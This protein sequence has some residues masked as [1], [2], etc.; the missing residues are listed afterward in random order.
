MKRICV[1]VLLVALF[2]CS[3]FAVTTEN[4]GRA[5]PPRGAA[6]DET[7][8][9]KLS[10][11]EG[12]FQNRLAELTLIVEGLEKR[13]GD[14]RKETTPPAPQD[15]ERLDQDLLLLEEESNSLMTP[16]L[17]P[18]AK[19][20]RTEMQDRL[21]EL[22][23]NLELMKRRW[24]GGWAV[25]GADFFRNSPPNQNPEQQSVPK[26]YRLR[27][28]DKL[29]VLVMSALGA[30][31]EYHLTV[32]S[33]GG[34]I[35]PGAG[36]VV[37][38]GKTTQ[39][40]EGYLTS[41]IASKFKQ[42][43]IDVSVENL[44]TI[45]VQVTG[46]VTRPG[47]YFL[48]GMP[49]VLNALYRAGGPTK[50]GTFRRMALIRDGEP[51]RL[52]DLYPFLLEGS[53]KQDL[54][55]EDGDVVFVPPVGPT[56]TVGGEVVR[57]GR[58]E[59]EYPTTLGKIL[60]MAG[61]AKSGGYLQTVQVERIENNQY[62][63]LLSE[64]MNG[65][66]GKSSF[67]LKPGDEVTVASVRQDR[68][69]Q[70]SITGPV[71][72]SGMYGFKEGMRVADL[73][74]LA[75]GLA[76]D[77]EV[78]GG[79]A[80]ILRIDPANG[81]EIVSYNLDKA[82]SGDAANNV[83]L[84]K[85]DRVFIYEPY[86]VVFKARLVTLSGAVARPG[87]YQRQGGMSVSDAIAA[88]GGVLPSAYMKRADL[89]RHTDGQQTELVRIDLQGALNGDPSANVKLADR[90]ELTIYAEDEVVWQDRKVRVEGAVQRAGTYTR[91]ENM[92]VSDLLFAAG[93]ELPE[94]ARVAEVARC[95]K[96]GI[97][98]VMKVDLTAL[99]ASPD[100]DLLLQEGDVVT[101]PSV[102]PYLRTPEVV[103]VTGEVAHPGPYAMM[104]PDER[105]SDLIARAGGVTKSADT[106]GCL[107]LR[108]KDNF[109]NAQ[110]QQDVDML[111]QRSQMLADKQFLTQLAKLGVRLPDQFMQTT[112]KSS[113]E[114]SK[115]A[116]VVPEEKLVGTGS[117]S[118]ESK[119]LRE[120]PEQA[121]GRNANG[122]G[123]NQ[124][125]SK[126]K[127]PNGTY[128][129]GVPLQKA[130]SEAELNTEEAMAA[131]TGSKI[132]ASAM[133]PALAGAAESASTGFKAKQELAEVVQSARISVNLTK[134][135]SE[136][137][138]P[139][140]MVLHNGDRVF[141]PKVTDVVTVIGA[142]LHPHSFSAGPGK[143]VD[144]YIQR[145]GGYSQEASKGQV[146]VVRANGDAVPKAMVRSVEPGD[147]IVV[148]TTG[149]I[150][151]ANKWE[152]VGGVTKVITD[153]L[154]S[155]FVLTRF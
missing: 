59:P 66:D 130:K 36:R 137:N 6:P 153:V 125:K 123:A 69:N 76:P 146:V 100:G 92:R 5:E 88:A 32:E 119:R 135:L 48:S 74:K 40:L 109:Q 141:V 144:F 41:K 148:P 68:T 53:K 51:K 116:E 124:D 89:M 99:A 97:S 101:V 150:D 47:T 39:Q 18:L 77:K 1:H 7:Q 140:N 29:R 43:R 8:A 138:S 129:N 136:P 50:S 86:Q 55:L 120:N 151:I 15:I 12:D 122:T 143:S 103:Y 19:L 70:V 28:G 73:V 126:E 71:G 105:I 45:Q 87:V 142:V 117:E 60:A 121:N 112:N 10:R 57:P 84:R 42:L 22:R 27:A 115:P 134:A 131:L 79:R 58:Y 106:N 17:S 52:I 98:T 102:N 110:Q 152:K 93:G 127:A 154:S 96:N 37:A 149:L 82:L 24:G 108:P 94:A 83:E 65:V 33:G 72:A 23:F 118:Q 85:L 78:Y 25:F 4:G 3:A 147:T 44:S 26:N 16:T 132:E 13:V 75:Q 81:V 133:G 46:D 64:P 113:S 80:D 62:K 21:F 9:E 56:V 14:M 20:Q 11:A 91:S 155:V 128:Q 90:D 63:V 31:N 139:D 2:A 49:T 35:V 38:A 34:I 145:S 61:G 107:F 67:V 114:L 30:Q 54:L 111:L 104:R 95:D